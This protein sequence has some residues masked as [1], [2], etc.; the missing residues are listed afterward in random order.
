MNTKNGNTNNERLLFHG[1]V[2]NSLTIINYKGFNRSY[3]GMN[4]NVL[5][6]TCFEQAWSVSV[7]I[8]ILYTCALCDYWL[9]SVGAAGVLGSRHG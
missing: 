7:S 8:C 2:N 6:A 4:G 5:R 1:T 9:L 3:A